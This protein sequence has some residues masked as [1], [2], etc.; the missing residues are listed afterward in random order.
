VNLQAIMSALPW[1]RRLWK[2]LPPQGRIVVLI[3]AAVAAFVYSRQ[4]SQEVAEA[5]QRL[6][7][8]GSVG[9]EQAGA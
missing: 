3:L 6:E 7:R 1:V 2:I 9:E 8:A 4:G 5:K